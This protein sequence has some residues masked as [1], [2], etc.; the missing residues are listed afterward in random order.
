MKIRDLFRENVFTLSNFLTISRVLA[1][2]FIVYYMI[3]EKNTGDALYGRYQFYFFLLIVFS[4]FFDGVI[5]RSY[6][7]VSKLGQFL[8]PIADKI[9]LLVLGSSLVYYKNFP[10]W[11]LLVSF[12]REAFFVISAFFLYYKKDVEVKPNILGK[13]SVACMAIS[14]VLYLL[15]VD[16][17]VYGSM[18][19]KELSVFMILVFYISGSILYVKTYSVYYK[20]RQ[21]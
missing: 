15:S 20:S 14:A 18:N 12:I 3:I 2:P 19:V 9:C 5:A 17:P 7:Q 6:N 21:A 11:M 16:Y 1:L 4:D 10:L 8:D 13:I